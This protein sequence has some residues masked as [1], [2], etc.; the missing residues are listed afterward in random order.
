MV[1]IPDQDTIFDQLEAELGYSTQGIQRNMILGLAKLLHRLISKN[2]SNPQK[3][4]EFIEN[5]LEAKKA[6]IFMN[7]SGEIASLRQISI[8]WL[9][10]ISKI[11]MNEENH[12][13]FEREDAFEFM[14]QMKISAEELERAGADPIFCRPLTPQTIHNMV[15]HVEKIEDQA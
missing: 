10:W 2:L 3:T 15:N 12:A 5:I 6:Q 4:K 13:D 1:Q 7:F 9:V 8:D 14:K 11:W